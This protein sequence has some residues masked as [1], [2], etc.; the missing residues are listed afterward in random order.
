MNDQPFKL[1][2]Y[3][4]YSA[5]VMPYIERELPEVEA[6]SDAGDADLAVMISHVDVY[7]LSQGEE[8]PET[9][10]LRNSSFRKEEEEFC[11]RA[12]EC[13][14]IIRTADIVG[15]GMTGFPMDLAK[16]IAS[17]RFF[18]FPD[19]EARRSVVHASDVARFIALLV[20]RK[21]TAAHRE[22]NLTDMSDPTIHDIAEA[23][24]YRMDNKRISTLSTGPQQWMGRKWYGRKLY[25]L[26]TT[27]VTY[28][29]ERV[30]EEFGFEPVPVTKYLRTHVYDHESL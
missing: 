4:P 12:G 26:Y 8:V 16:A 2:V 25:A 30:K 1:H 18:H 13:G 29:A 19:N 3:A 21:G 6:V 10:M 5:F 9:A 7:G 24:A 11:C 22:Y 27:T 28:S 14:I 15:T 23:L 20:S 17:G